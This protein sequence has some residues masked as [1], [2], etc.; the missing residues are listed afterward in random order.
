MRKP[1]ALFVTPVLPLAG[2]SGRALRAWDWLQELNQTYRVH[3]L[4]V[5][6]RDVW[7]ELPA[8]YPAEALWPLV[9]ATSVTRGVTRL[10]G[11][12]L[13][14]LALLSPRFV[15]DWQH[16]RCDDYLDELLTHLNGDPVVRIVVFRLY[17][18]DLG[19]RLAV[20]FPGASCAL[21]LDDLESCT[22]FSIAQSCWR[23][24]HLRDALRGASTAIQY[25]CVERR[26]AAHYQHIYLAAN[27]DG[28]RLAS[29]L[30]SRMVCRP[31]RIALPV[32]LPPYL[33]STEFGLL[34]V[35]TLNYPPNEEAVRFLVTQIVPRLQK[36]LQVP[37]RLRIVGRHASV[38]LQRLL[39]GEPCVEFIP[40]SADLEDIYA[41]S[42]IALVPLFAGGGTK[43]KTLEGFAHRRAVIATCHGV[44]GIAARSGEHY[45]LAS[46]AESFS[47]AIS[48]L[49]ERRD[50]AERIAHAGWVLCQQEYA[51]A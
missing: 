21:D 6:G 32:D 28:P 38:H 7:P 41:C 40:Q 8:D 2:G 15:T 16:W 43:L 34:F 4:V 45:L 25:F 24:G 46:C 50:M 14:V 10:A 1:I 42:H 5:E 39:Q 20:R 30:R 37:W 33:P 47:T 29:P 36:S 44:R 11:L 18:N 49:A 22:R 27:E 19:R 13:P 35:G 48:V 12:L 3:V 26:I 31:N 23:M 17:L 9:T 51:R